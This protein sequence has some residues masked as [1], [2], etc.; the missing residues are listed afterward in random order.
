MKRIIIMTAVLS[1]AFTTGV[2]SQDT[3]DSS[4][5]SNSSAQ[6]SDATT[7]SRVSEK[8]GMR[9]LEHRRV[10]EMIGMNITNREDEK[11][12][13][14][15]DLILNLTTRQVTGV[16]ISSG[17]FLGIAN[18]L[19]IMPPSA[20]ELNAERDVLIANVSKDQ[21][22]SA[23]RF[24]D[25]AYPDLDDPELM[26]NVYKAYDAEPLLKSNRS[27][28][29]PDSRNLRVVR[30]S[31]I[32]GLTVKNLQ[33]ESIGDIYEVI[34]NGSHDRVLS[35]VVSS[36]GFLGIGDTLSVLPAESVTVTKDAVVVNA[37]KETLEKSPRFNADAWKES[38][39]DPDYLVN[40]YAPYQFRGDTKSDVDVSRD[41]VKDGK[42][43]AETDTRE[44]KKNPSEVT[45]QDQKNNP[46]DLAVTMNIRRKIVPD[47]NLSFSARN[48][49][50][51]TQGGKTTLAG[52]VASKEEMDRILS[53]TKD[54][55]PSED[56]INQLTLDE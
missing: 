49:R 19:S 15:D 35:V 14:I 39:N 50:V 41:R 52:Q 20:L 1:T 8:P 53:I 54:E 38:V 11:V 27:T 5:P 16:V 40:I 34:L 4:K 30:A 55:A 17:G 2:H 42:D 37:T 28:N 25:D 23:P 18:E 31:K 26:K 3:V 21:L 7:S 24:Q 10:S 29:S 9:L 44:H 43:S 6:G 22:T 33:D 45:A 32:L 13:A 51:I 12:G 56:V 36:G 48:I 46:E 47:D